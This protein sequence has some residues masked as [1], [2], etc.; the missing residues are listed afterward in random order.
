MLK[1]KEA[2]KCLVQVIEANRQLNA[3]ETLAY[4]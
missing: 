1:T 3:R 2:E 4:W